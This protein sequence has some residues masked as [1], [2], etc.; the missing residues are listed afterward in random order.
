MK[1]FKTNSRGFSRS[2]RKQHRM[3]R[4]SPMRGGYR[5]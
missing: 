5:V 4:P 2:A 3:N 1:R